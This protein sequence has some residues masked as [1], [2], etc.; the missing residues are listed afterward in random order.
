M[1]PDVWFELHYTIVPR[2]KHPL[3]WRHA[4]NDARKHKHAIT[5]ISCFL[6][7]KGNF[8]TIQHAAICHKWQAARQQPSSSIKWYT[9]RVYHH[10]GNVLTL[11]CHCLRSLHAEETRSSEVK[12]LRHGRIYLAMQRR[13]VSLWV[14][15]CLLPSRQRH[16]SA[17]PARPYQD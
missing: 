11:L 4:A 15:A 3:G 2:Y 17:A 6:P 10:S 7:T 13:A 5:V 16:L 9:V 12:P 14:T 1:T 8:E